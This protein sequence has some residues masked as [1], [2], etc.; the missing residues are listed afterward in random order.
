MPHSSQFSST[1]LAN[2]ALKAYAAACRMDVEDRAAIA[3]KWV[4]KAESDSPHQNLCYIA[5]MQDISSGCYFRLRLYLSRKGKMD[6]D[7]R[8]TRPTE[9][10][11]LANLPRGSDKTPGDLIKSWMAK[12]LFK[13]DPAD[14]YL[15]P[16]DTPMVFPAHKLV[17]SQASAAFTSSP[18]GTKLSATATAGVP[19]V[20]V[21]ETAETV[22]NLLRC[23]YGLLPSRSEIKDGK[24]VFDL[25]Q[26]AFKYRMLKLIQTLRI[27]LVPLIKTC[28]VRVYFLASS[29][30]WHDK[31]KEAALRAADSSLYIDNVYTPEMEV[32]SARM[33]WSLLHVRAEVQAIIRGIS[34]GFWTERRAP[35]GEN[36]PDG[37]PKKKSRMAFADL[38]AT[39]AHFHEIPKES[40]RTKAKSETRTH[41]A[42]TS[43]KL[44]PEPSL[45]PKRKLDAFKVES[46]ISPDVKAFNP[47]EK[48]YAGMVA[49][50]FGSEGIAKLVKDSK[51]MDAAIEEALRK[52]HLSLI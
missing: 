42:H 4:L 10:Q 12:R 6:S 2:E 14:V 11:R 52:V 13:D 51:A 47:M 27:L 16:T 24:V 5:G 37:P 41:H 21:P 46:N 34:T 32:T 36:L 20:D 8:F 18:P 49:R 29:M 48:I 3:A 43:S 40:S 23:C 45:G 33:Y 39:S 25:F 50:E 15:R 17:L 9:E 35:A 28:P 38:R 7:F 19:V 44:N 30:G 1:T 22:H 31:A 26:V